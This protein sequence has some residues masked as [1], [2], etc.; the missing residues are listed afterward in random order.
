M[1]EVFTPQAR[2]KPLTLYS[3]NPEHAQYGSNG[4][5]AIEFNNVTD[6]RVLGIKTE[7]WAD[8]IRFTDSDNVMLLGLSIHTGSN[9]WAGFYDCSNFVAVS[10]PRTNSYF[11]PAQYNIVRYVSSVAQEVLLSKRGRL[12]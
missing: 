7:A 9:P 8:P 10:V 6:A 1:P 3:P 5:R 4:S 11:N 12:F 2:H